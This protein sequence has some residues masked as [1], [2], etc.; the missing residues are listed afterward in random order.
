MCC[1]LLAYSSVLYIPLCFYALQC[2][3]EGYHDPK[4]RVIYLHMR[5]VFDV[6]TL[7]KSYDL[8]SKELEEKVRHSCGLLM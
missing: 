4:Q 3:I 6:H 5:G 2:A 8:F 7:I 1:I